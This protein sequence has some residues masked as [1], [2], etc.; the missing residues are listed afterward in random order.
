MKRQFKKMI[1]GMLAL[2]VVSG[3]YAWEKN[4]RNGYLAQREPKN[5]K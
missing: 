5:I 1:L 3:T 2:S 4:D